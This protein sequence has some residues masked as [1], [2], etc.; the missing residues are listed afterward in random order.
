MSLQTQRI[1]L[2]LLV[3]LR[4]VISIAQVTTQTLS[5]DYLGLSI[6]SNASSI[7][8]VKISYDGKY[9]AYEIIREN[10]RSMVI[11]SLFNDWNKQIS[12][13][14]S[15]DFTED[16]KGVFLAKQGDTLCSIRLGSDTIKYTSNVKEHRLIK[17][18]YGQ[19]LIYTLN[20]PDK[21]LR[22]E[23]IKTGEIQ[24]FKNVN[25]YFL[26]QNNRLLLFKKGS[27]NKQVDSLYAVDIF[28]GNQSFLYAGKN[29][30]NIIFSTNGF[31]LSF[32]LD[33][34]FSRRLISF[35]RDADNQNWITESPF[36]PRVGN[37]EVESILRYDKAGARLFVR[38]KGTPLSE[39]EKKSVPV[40]IWNFQD[41]MLQSQQL[42]EEEA[43]SY[44]FSYDLF[45]KKLIQ[46]HTPNEKICFSEDD[47]LAVVTK[48]SGGSENEWN[49]NKYSQ[50]Q[51]FLLNTY[52]G[53]GETLSMS[54]AGFLPGG[55]YI[56]GRNL[57][58]PSTEDAVIIYDLRTKKY[59]KIT[60]P[61]R[62]R[63]NKQNLR[64]SSETTGFTSV[65]NASTYENYRSSIFAFSVTGDSILIYDGYDMWMV[66]LE[67]ME[68][69]VCITNGYG[70]KNSISFK[71]ILPW[72]KPFAIG[73][74]M[75]LKAFDEKWK[76]EGL[77]SITIGEGKNPEKLI[78]QA[79]TISY[80]YPRKARDAEVYLIKLETATN[81]S[82]LFWTTDFKK[83]HPLIA[84]DSLADNAGFKS[85]LIAWKSLDGNSLQ[86]VVYK[87]TE[88]ISSKKYPVIFLYY[89]SLSQE[90]NRYKEPA[91]SSANINIPFFL[92]AGYIVCTPD[93]RYE[94][95]HTGKSAYNAVVSCA[96]YLQGFSWVDGKHMGLQGHSFGAYET[97]YII[98]HSN[99]FAAA[100]S[101]SGICNMVSDYGSLAFIENFDKKF[102]YENHQYR[103][104]ASLWETPN[105]YIRNSPIFYADKV[106]TPLLMMNNKKDKAVSFGQGVE[107]FT[108]LRRLGKRVWMLQYDE[109]SHT[110][111]QSKEAAI[112]YT[113]RM[114][115]FFDHYLKD[116]SCPRWMLYGIPAK[117]KGIDNGYE[118]VREKDPKTGKW[119]TPKEGGLLTDEERI[120]VEALKRRKPVTVTIE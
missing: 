114:K 10:Q 92:K 78:M 118:L 72:E 79:G 105:G 90:L 36:T 116:S 75:I 44:L 41:K 19:F 61:I 96:K 6:A 2:L 24:F 50:S 38:M 53:T 77:F 99:L 104:G 111:S 66:D 20:I 87:P 67:S 48:N 73:D 45:T 47:S 57:A 17:N 71:S 65:A 13:I 102:F 56:N 89:E 58:L 64:S 37:L 63:I 39:K 54:D 94:V 5:K 110:L 98:T 80:S 33:E 88:F 76:D 4:N 31:R 91:V 84:G 113:I 101:A 74:K 108:A 14:S 15:V 106:S 109:G 12:S 25:E 32:L 117:D 112:D 27:V 42:L 3:L 95:G 46:L 70:R 120:K 51:F 8:N 7:G 60:C 93:I 21:E 107:F 18:A 115:Q 119:L 11:K 29:I 59:R 43:N 68:E 81:S 40:D 97:N 86:G 1:S 23:N 100:V 22:I 85:E 69:P 35:Q 82:S 28:N 9:V 30:D 34:S 16:N 103:M 62:D 55:R 52:N 49:W 83:Y 26:H